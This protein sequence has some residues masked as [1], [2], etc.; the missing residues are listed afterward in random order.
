M[1]TAG[2]VGR[3][4]VLRL[5]FADFTRATRSHTLPQATAETHAILIAAR[6]LLANAMP[7]IDRQG[8]TLVGISVSNL[9]N[10]DAVQ[11]ALP[12]DQWS[13]GALDEALDEVRARYGLDAVT[14]GVLLGRD[15]GLT[16]PMLP[17]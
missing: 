2:R 4:I 10:D 13:G 16:M 15:Q 7:M 1:R 5:R 8:I 12:F 9:E 17:D 6:E 3:T 11:L 14:R